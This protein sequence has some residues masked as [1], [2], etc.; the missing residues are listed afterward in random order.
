MLTTVAQQLPIYFIFDKILRY[1]IN[2]KF[3]IY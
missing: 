2:D 1:Y 3:K